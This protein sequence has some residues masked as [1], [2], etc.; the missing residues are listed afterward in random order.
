MTAVAVTDWRDLGACVSA[1][2]ELFF[3]IS[4]SGASQQQEA[5]AKAICAACTVRPDC[6]A[7]ALN[8]NELHGVWGGLGEE[9]RNRL[10]REAA[11]GSSLPQR[12]PG[13]GRVSKPRSSQPGSATVYAGAQ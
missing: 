4:V 12:L 5:Q 2:P 6:L 7:F 13:T 3:P 11:D 10:R 9:E 8:T 1:D